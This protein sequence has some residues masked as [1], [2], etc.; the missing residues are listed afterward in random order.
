MTKARQLADLGNKTS[1]DEINDAYDAG[2]LSNRNL[3]INGAMQ[4]AQR[5]TSSTDQ[6]YQCVDRWRNSNH[7]SQTITKSQETL[8]SGEPYDAGFRKFLRMTQGAENS[9]TT[10]YMQMATRIEGL[11]I[12]SS[13]WQYTS[14]SSHITASFWV[15]SSL[16]GDYQI[17]TQTRSSSGDKYYFKKFNLVADTWKKVT[18]SIAGDPAIAIDYDNTTGLEFRIVPYYGTDYTGDRSSDEGVWTDY[19]SNELDDFPQ[20]WCATSGATFDFTG[21]QLEVGDTATPFEH[22][23]YGEELAKCQRYY[24]RDNI[25]SNDHALSTQANWN[26]THFFGPYYMPVTMRANPTGSYS[27]LSNFTLYQ[28]SQTRTLTSLSFGASTSL[29]SRELTSHV[30][31]SITPQGG[32]GWLRGQGTG[33]IAL[34]AEL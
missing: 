6:N 7:T 8:T 17:Y 29:N 11:D 23:S 26:T 3:I 9:A 25:A 21:V 13:G 24:Y 10:D 12:A 28:N 33:W 2:A 19:N 20:N 5:G 14:S 31:S 4:V 32:A 30:S 22:R 34:D 27:A 1:L 15:R 16:A 18:C